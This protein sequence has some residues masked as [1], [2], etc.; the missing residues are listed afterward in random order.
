MAQNSLKDLSVGWIGTGRMGF[1]MASRLLDAGADVTAWNRTRAKADPL[2]EKGGKV[3]DSPTELA[4]RDV[5][6]T[7][8]GGPKDFEEVA[9]GEHGVLSQGG[10]T[11][12]MLIDCTSINEESSKKVRNYAKGVGTEMIDAPVSGNH[13]VV[14][15]GKL[16]IVASGDAASF[17]KARPFLE[18]IGRGVSYVGEGEL[19]RMV[20]ICHNVMLGVVAQ[21]MAE[22]TVLAEK[23][24]VPRQAFLDFINNSVMGSMF[25]TYKTPAFVNLD[26]TPTFTPPLL[27]KDMDLGLSAARELGVPMPVTA[28]AREC[29]QSIIGQGYLEEDFATLLLHE[30]ANAGLDISSEEKEV[31]TGL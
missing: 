7:M 11:P 13:H 4:D 30:A 1:A 25:T 26:M 3:V 18:A 28:A 17:E 23:G 14:V 31:D 6:F 21:N 8:V 20:K 2:M 5:V 9:M 16:S 24:G 19:A 15:A 10:Q 22:I 29:V 27:R 12:G